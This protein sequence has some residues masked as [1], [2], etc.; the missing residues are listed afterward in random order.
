MSLEPDWKID[1]KKS[2]LFS[3]HMDFDNLL[4]RSAAFIFINMSSGVLP[5]LSIMS[6]FAPLDVKRLANSVQIS[7]PVWSG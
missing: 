7:E 6:T 5:L 3:Y 4:N 2:K 1:A